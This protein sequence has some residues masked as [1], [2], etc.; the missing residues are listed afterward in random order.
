MGENSNQKT[1][2]G[3]EI[4]GSF[5]II[6]SYA[7]KVLVVI[8]N[9]ILT[10]L[11][12]L[13]ITGVICAC[14]FAVYINNYVDTEIDETMFRFTEV[15]SGTASELYRY[16]WTDRLNRVGE[17][18]PLDGEQIHGS[19][20]SILV[21]YDEIPENLI[22]AFIAVED[23]RFRDH[24]GVDWIRSGAAFVNFFVGSDTYG[25]ST[26]TQQLIKNV[27]GDDSYKIQRKI[28]E[29]FW[30]LDLEKK[31]DKTA[32]LTSY[33]NIVGLANGYTGVGAAAY[34]YFSKDVSELTLLECAAIAGI[35]KNPTKY[36]PIANPENNF[37]RR[38]T[39]LWLML[40]QGLI[41][42][43]EYDEVEGKEPEWNV[44]EEEQQKTKNVNSW[45]VDMVINDVIDDLVEIGYTVEAANLLVYSGGL[46]IY[47]AIDPAIQAA[48]EEIYLN[49]TYFRFPGNVAIPQSSCMV[50]D[51]YTGDILGV[52][53]AVGE[54]TANR[55][56]SF[57][58]D[59][60]R[61]VGSSIKPI[62]VYAPAFEYGIINW[63]TAI[64]D[65]PVNF[66][67][68]NK[69]AWPQNV[70]RVYA[71][72]VTVK[73]SVEHSLNTSSIKTLSALTVDKS[74]DFLDN[75]LNFKSL[76]DSLTLVNGTTLTDRGLAALG[77]GQFNY[78]ITLRELVGGYTM[79]P[80]GGVFSEPRSYIEVRDKEGNVILD[81][82]SDTN[83]RKVVISEET[84]FQMTE[85]LKA[86]VTGSTWASVRNMGLQLAGKTGTTQ[87]RYD[88]TFVGF[89]PYYLCGV[90]VG[91]EY[92]K[93]MPG[94]QSKKAALVWS[95][96]MST[97]HRD[98]VDDAKESG[99]ALR[100]FDA[101]P[102]NIVRVKYCVDSGKLC[103]TACLKD[104]RKNRQVEGYA[105]RG[106]EPTEY[107]DVHKLVK[108][109]G[110]NGGVAGFD[111]PP[112]NITY[113][114]LLDIERNFPISLRV[115]DAEY[116]WREL[117]LK[118]APHLSGIF[119]F[120]Y[121][122]TEYTGVYPGVSWVSSGAK[123]QFNR[124]ASAY[125]NYEQW[126]E[127]AS[128]QTENVSPGE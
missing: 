25:G 43:A 88:Y 6:G 55:V 7:L 98:I 93:T 8:F 4:L 34:G 18:V 14:A 71:G 2:W 20:K 1:H 21:S 24:E 64:E 126:Q 90:W 15:V 102:S 108:Y 9:I 53:G 58:T 101:A 97:I 22:N 78:G 3:K 73:Y 11:L 5:G 77:L 46:K 121:N 127:W 57:A 19:N 44:P 47:T 75:D 92:P 105:V 72:R 28:Q 104:P 109:D 42:Q 81:N 120:Y 112:E 96:V 106:D 91:Y 27:T 17:P 52:A 114:G 125:F 31:M 30:A 36:D 122:I 65:T 45:Y 128:K 117:P 63:R 16:D 69:T 67:W 124:Y 59:A 89:T 83:K 48:L 54:K 41:T 123:Q 100:T 118:Y 76:I 32:I 85:C 74:F 107:C 110:V 23:K 39:V 95:L 50:V 38:E 103:T 115:T 33:M 116:T 99:E 111:C 113:V 82:E 61:P 40:E 12:I 79:F 35:T 37:D 56:Q 51:P 80:S 66:G 26:I 10:L 60:V 68:N 86:V 29:I 119:P 94:D 87:D 49:E 84:A 62:A 70:D 13:A